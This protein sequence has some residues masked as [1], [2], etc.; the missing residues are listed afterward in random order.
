MSDFTAQELEALL[1]LKRMRE[2]GY[3]ESKGS[4]PMP[5]IVADGEGPDD[6]WLP[7]Y[8]YPEYAHEYEDKERE[9][10]TRIAGAKKPSFC[11]YCGETLHC[12]ACRGA[13][14]GHHCQTCGQKDNSVGY[15][16]SCSGEGAHGQ[17]AG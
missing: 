16:P 3:F 9:A 12:L 14:L 7:D 10:F 5:E 11:E 17:T 13:G 2:A 8:K 15:C 4:V 6:G 1:R